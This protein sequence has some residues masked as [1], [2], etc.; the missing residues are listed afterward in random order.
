M[1]KK[2]TLWNVLNSKIQDDILRNVHNAALIIGDRSHKQMHG[3][4]MNRY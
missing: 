1:Y 3:R 2:V 4:C